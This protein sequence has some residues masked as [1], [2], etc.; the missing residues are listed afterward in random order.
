MKDEAG[1]SDVHEVLSAPYVPVYVQLIPVKQD[2]PGA[3]GRA[4]ILGFF[5]HLQ[6]SVE[7]PD[8]SIC[9]K[10]RC[11][12]TESSTPL[13]LPLCVQKAL[14]RPVGMQKIC[15]AATDA[16]W[17]KR[18][19][20]DF[21]WTK[22]GLERAWHY[23]IGRQ[24]FADLINNMPPVLEGVIRQVCG[25]LD[26]LMSYKRA[27]TNK[28]VLLQTFEMNDSVVEQE[29][30]RERVSEREES[31]RESG[32]ACTHTQQKQTCSC[33]YIYECVYGCMYVCM[34]VCMYVYDKDNPR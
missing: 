10:S 31:E 2:S 11:I 14:I 12:R 13:E 34:H 5:D 20:K 22:D 18:I 24:E 29:E 33:T 15:S 8:C 23:G 21:D 16:V 7:L 28:A 6:D 25:S 32:C 1:T 27:K 17:E 26:V 19:S 3:A 4:L 30:V 9:G